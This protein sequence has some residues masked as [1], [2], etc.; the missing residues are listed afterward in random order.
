MQAATLYIIAGFVLPLVVLVALFASKWLSYKNRRSILQQ[1]L[2]QRII[3]DGVGT[4]KFR[5]ESYQVIL[6]D[7]RQYKAYF[8]PRRKVLMNLE[9]VR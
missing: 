3:Q 9:V 5:K 7:R 2:N 8:T 6:L 4:L 1:E